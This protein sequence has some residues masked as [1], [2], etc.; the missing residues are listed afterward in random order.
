MQPTGFDSWFHVAAHRPPALMLTGAALDAATACPHPRCCRRLGGP[1]CPSGRA[2]G[3]PPR[4]SRAALSP[5]SGA[6]ALRGA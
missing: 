3:P 6:T 4:L 1:S 5:L 2:R